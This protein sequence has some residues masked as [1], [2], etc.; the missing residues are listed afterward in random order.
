M[1]YEVIHSVVD[2]LED[3]SRDKAVRNS[4]YFQWGTSQFFNNLLID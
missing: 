2:I 3:K 1:Y 4:M